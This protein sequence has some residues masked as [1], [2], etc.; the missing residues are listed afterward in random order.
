MTNKNETS[1]VSKNVEEAIKEIE[2]EEQQKEVDKIKNIVRKYLEKIADK[3]KQEDEVRKERLALE[4]DLDDLKAGRLDKIEERQGKDPVHDKVKII[5]IHKIVE[6]YYPAYPWRSP[7]VI[8]WY[9]PNYYGQ[10]ITTS[11]GY[12]SIGYL[13]AN[14][15]GSSLGMIT[16]NTGSQNFMNQMQSV[17]NLASQITGQITGTMFQN[18]CGGSYDIGG[19]I[20]NL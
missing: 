20:I 14:N 2:K 17:S 13:Q 15:T 10:S 1:T 7:Y 19:N 3:K 5:E 6:H 18:F 4:K 9:E 12:S 11:S 8:N 16:S